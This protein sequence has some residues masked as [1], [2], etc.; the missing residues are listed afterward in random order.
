MVNY[1]YLLISVFTSA[2]LSIVSSL[3]SEKN[4]DVKDTS[5]FYVAAVAI[6]AF[7][8]WGVI[9]AF[10]FSFDARVIFYS[11]AYAVF[12]VSAVLGLFTAMETGAVSL[13]AF[14]KQ[15]SLITIAVWGFIFWDTPIV[16]NVV[17]GLVLMVLALYL[18]FKPQKDGKKPVTFKWVVGAA[19]LILGN[20]GSTILQ[21]Y[22]QMHFDGQ[23]KSMLMFFAMGFASLLCLSI[24]FFKG[25]CRM[26]EVRRISLLY[27]A[28]G[29]MCSAAFN[30]LV[31]ILHSTTIPENVTFPTAAVGG[32]LVTSL[33]SVIFRH[34]KLKTHQWAGLA[35]G[36][37]S[38]VFLNI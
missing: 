37:V 30:I 25:G 12:Y 10:D 7:V 22:E 34:E 19:M 5:F 36:A 23:H 15:L 8:S 38:L 6:S 3:F 9:Y 17:V 16:L 27:P 33:F 18:C 26:R 24:R 28:I 2:A 20:G 4:K 14:V 21:K 1:L 13:T 35:V 32:M 11:L 29:G 31:L